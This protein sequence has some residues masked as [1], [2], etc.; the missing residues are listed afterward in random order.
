LALG[1]G[2][3][4][5]LAGAGRLLELAA[6]ALVLGLQVAEASLKGLAAGTRDGLYTSIIGPVQAAA[7]PPRPRSRN[8][9]QVDPERA[10][11]IQSTL[12]AASPEA[13]PHAAS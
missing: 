5:A 12:A 1:E 9:C 8:Q 13:K 7:A 2:S 6:E 4:R 11:L 3:N 10:R